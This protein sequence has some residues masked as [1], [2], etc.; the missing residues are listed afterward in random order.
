MKDILNDLFLKEYKIIFK[1]YKPIKKIGE[2]S[3]GN[4]YSTIRL[5]DKSVFAMKT[6]KIDTKKKC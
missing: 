5:K 1:K 3:F 2:G 4:V 6:E